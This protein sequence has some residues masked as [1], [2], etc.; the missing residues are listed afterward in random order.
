MNNILVLDVENTIHVKSYYN[1]DMCKSTITKMGPFHPNNK[2]VSV[3]IGINPDDVNDT[4]YYCFNHN[5]KSM[6]EGAFEAVQKHL[7]KADLLIGHNL[8]HDMHWLRACGFEYTGK[9][10]DTQIAEFV[11]CRSIK[12]PLALK[13]VAKRYEAP[14]KRTDI[15]D[16]YMK[17]GIMFDTIPWDIVEEYG[18]GDI[19]TTM[20]VYLT[21]QK[22][23]KMSSNV[24]LLPTVR[25][26]CDFLHAIEEMEFN[27]LSIDF[28]ALNEVENEY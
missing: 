22:L 25:M 12:R 23:F 19:T 15:I 18:R 27:G 8:K 24:G 3:G 10:W 6:D 1:R 14:A 21:Q 9:L 26:M 20:A 13:H 16:E 4:E 11:L 2:L 7:D 28:D 17:D 5:E